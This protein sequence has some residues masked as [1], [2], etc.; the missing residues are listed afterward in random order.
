M[1]KNLQAHGWFLV[2]IRRIHKINKSR[3]LEF[4]A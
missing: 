4:P 3:G 2:R 1:L